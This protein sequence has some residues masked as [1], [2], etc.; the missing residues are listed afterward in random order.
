MK[1]SVLV[2][3]FVAGERV[4]KYRF[5][6]LNHAKAIHAS[7]STPILGVSEGSCAEGGVLDV[8]L[9][10]ISEVKLASTVQENEKLSSTSA[11]LAIAHSETARVGG[12]ALAS[13]VA[14]DIIPV[15]L[16][17]S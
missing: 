9:A 16:A 3:A 10:G 6:R 4:E 8:M 12:I 13:G 5:V 2:S 17:Q 7:D 1:K 14:G 11:G 15:L